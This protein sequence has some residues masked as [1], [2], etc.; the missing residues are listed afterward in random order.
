MSELSGGNIDG[1]RAPLLGIATRNYRYRLMCELMDREG[2]DALAFTT[3]SFFQFATNFATDVEPWERPILCVV[4]RN[5]C[6][7]AVLNELS[8]H[9]WRFGRESNRLWVNDAHFYAEYPV[10]PQRGIPRIAHWGELVVEGLRK[11]GLQR[12]RIG[13]DGGNLDDVSRLLSSVVFVDMSMRCRELRFAKHEEEIAVMRQA[14]ALSDWRRIDTA[15]TSLPEGS[16]RSWTRA[17]Q[18]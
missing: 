3:A 1:A 8:R 4:P 15:R 12:G 10:T 13:L 7:F 9:H 18:R 17:W 5:G 16:C 2:V 6:P 11:A 14:S